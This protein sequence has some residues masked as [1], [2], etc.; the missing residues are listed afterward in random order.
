M[1]LSSPGSDQIDI[2][3]LSLVKG[4]VMQDFGVRM[5]IHDNLGMLKSC[6]ND[7]DAWVYTV[8]SSS[9]VD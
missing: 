8:E 5:S 4:T 7:G 2:F 9:Q 6:S 3:C 1:P